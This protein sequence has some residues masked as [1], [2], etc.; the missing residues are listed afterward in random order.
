MWSNWA[1]LTDL[2]QLTMVGGYVEE[3]KRD[4]L[5]NFDYFFRRVP[6][7]GGYCVLAGLE[8]LIKYI[9]ALRFSKEDLSYLE[10]LGIFS[11]QVLAYMKD[12]K[13]TG[14]LCAVPEG[15]VVF[16]HEPLERTVT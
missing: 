12:F 1:S 14:D 6:D 11:D 4:Q 13:F 2:Y 8:D 16:P 9:K 3:G 7:D 5:A 10:G 15:S